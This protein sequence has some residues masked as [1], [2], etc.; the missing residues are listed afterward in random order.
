MLRTHTGTKWQRALRLVLQACSL[1]PSVST[2][3][4]SLLLSVSLTLT[5]ASSQAVLGF[6]GGVLF[7]VEQGAS[8]YNIDM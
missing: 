7:V 6:A 4:S 2:F 3:F 1:P 5:A 8:H